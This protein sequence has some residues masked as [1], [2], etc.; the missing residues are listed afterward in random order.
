MLTCVYVHVDMPFD[1]CQHQTKA[2]CTSHDMSTG[3]CECPALTHAYGY[4]FYSSVGTLTVV[5]LGE[6][7]HH[8]HTLVRVAPPHIPHMQ[9]IQRAALAVPL[10][11][12]GLKKAS[13][14]GFFR[15]TLSRPFGPMHGFT[16]HLNSAAGPSMWSMST[17]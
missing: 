7:P 9:S 17:T 16:G 6:S 12:L 3:P 1:A 15:P 14:D 13:A 11:R 2:C 10:P 5:F 4:Q 8:L